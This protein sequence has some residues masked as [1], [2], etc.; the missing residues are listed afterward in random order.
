MN[1]LINLARYQNLSLPDWIDWLLLAV[2]ANTTNKRFRQTLEIACDCDAPFET[3]RGTFFFSGRRV[4]ASSD[5]LQ[6]SDN[7]Q[8]VN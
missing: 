8:L 5:C 4:I 6:Q 7:S 1:M 3:S 2:I